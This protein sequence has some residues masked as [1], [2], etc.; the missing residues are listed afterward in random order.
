MISITCK[1]LNKHSKDPQSQL[2][3]PQPGSPPAFT[4]TFDGSY[5][6]G[7]DG[8]VLAGAAAVLRGPVG[9]DLGRAT[10]AVFQARVAAD[11]G[12]GAEALA[13]A[14]G[15]GLLRGQPNPGFCLVVGDSPAVITWGPAQHTCAGP[16]RPSR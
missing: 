1:S 2:P 4:L 15:L 11:S 9:A 6:T 14:G 13:C 8:T 16:T 5:G 7:A 3:Y 10:L 12:L